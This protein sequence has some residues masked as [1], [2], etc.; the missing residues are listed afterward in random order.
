M[1]DVKDSKSE[2]LERLDEL[3]EEFKK[4]EPCPYC[5]PNRCPACGRVLDNPLNDPFIRP[6]IPWC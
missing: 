2:T 4:S 5:H 6:Y 1:E 3:R